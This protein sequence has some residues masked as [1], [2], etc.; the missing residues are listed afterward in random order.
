MKKESIGTIIKRIRKEKNLSQQ[1]FAEI[2]GLNNS[3]ISKWEHDFITPD[4]T[5]LRIISDKF[6]IPLDKL[7]DGETKSI[8]K[9]KK[10]LILSIIIL[11]ETIALFL[12]VFHYHNEE[13][14]TL[15]SIY[16]SNDK[17][18]VK[19][20][21][22]T[23]GKK[24]IINIYKIE[25]FQKL[26]GTTKQLIPE[27][28]TIIFNINNKTIENKHLENDE[29]LSLEELLEDFELNISDEYQKEDKYKIIVSIQNS[30]QT[31]EI[32]LNINL[33]NKEK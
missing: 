16:S 6:N 26:I 30:N 19:G 5:Y 23:N 11:L 29:G 15:Y 33:I 4:I 14:P 31:E 18:S 3:T 20:V 9:S 7:I 13:Q 21:A 1:Q 32:S 10:V 12:I 17:I 27:N 28:V 25:Y 22:V 8:K 2:L 24:I